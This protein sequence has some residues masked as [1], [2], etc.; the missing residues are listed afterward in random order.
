MRLLRFK[1]SIKKRRG[2]AGFLYLIM[3][4]GVISSM[5][6]MGTVRLFTSSFQACNVLEDEFKKLQAMHTG[7]D[8]ARA[9]DYD[10]L[11][12]GTTSFD[13]AGYENRFTVSDG[14]FDN[15]G[16]KIIKFS[17]QEYPNEEEIV[18]KRIRREKRGFP[19]GTIL[20]YP[21]NGQPT[22]GGIWLPC[23]GVTDISKYKELQ[24]ILGGRTTTPN[25]RNYYLRGYGYSHWDDSLRRWLY[26]SGE[27]LQPQQWQEQNLNKG[28][29]ADSGRKGDELL[30]SM[31]GQNTY[32]IFIPQL[33]L[34]GQ[35]Q[36]GKGAGIVDYNMAKTYG[37][38][39][40]KAFYYR[41]QVAIWETA[42]DIHKQDYRNATMGLE[43]QLDTGAIQ[44][45]NT[46][47]NELR[48]DTKI[49]AYFI[50]AQ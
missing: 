28:G 2:N 21:A 29:S 25:L 27:L 15:V 44:P 9:I 41:N 42:F 13:I 3:M 45:A 18:T 6:A 38:Y 20:A 33:V 23:D 1:Q 8:Y 32:E 17:T 30:V 43:L 46:D 12:N 47:Q 5:L 4:L 31:S 49:V 36:N 37:Y 16:C 24:K 40:Y 11:K 26:K 10:K 35:R 19:V 48:P 22:A 39:S 14:L 50:K 34:S 7:I